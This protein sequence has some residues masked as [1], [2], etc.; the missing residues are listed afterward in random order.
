MN[1]F[2]NTTN[3]LAAAW[4]TTMFAIVWQSTRVGIIAA[5]VCRLLRRQSPAL[6]YWIWLAVA[7]KL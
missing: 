7:A 6:R 1:S 5:V 4:A 2:I 3:D